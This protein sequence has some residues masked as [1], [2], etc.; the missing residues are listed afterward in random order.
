VSD[1][2][3]FRTQA[4]LYLELSRRMSLRT[5]A[6]FCRVR[7]ARNLAAAVELERE[8]PGSSSPETSSSPEASEESDH[9]AVLFPRGL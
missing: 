9:A 5:D 1:A 8:Q 6:E 7:A 4:E 2:H 3:H